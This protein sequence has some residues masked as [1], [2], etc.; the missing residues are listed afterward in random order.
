MGKIKTIN[1]LMKYMRDKHH[2]SIEGANDK[3]KLMN[4]GYYHGYKGYRYIKNPSNRLQ[5]NEFNEL[6][7]II[8]FDNNTKAILYPQVM[9]IETALKSYVLE[10]IVKM[11]KTDNFS[12]V[13]GEL[14]T[15]YKAFNSQSDVYKR[16]YK[17]RLDT[18]NIIQNEI[19]NA[20][21]HDSQI[22]SHYL[23]KD[24]SIPIWAIFEILT[25]G[26]FGNFVS[27]L[28]K[29]C[30]LA[31]SKELRLNSAFDSDGKMTESVIFAL[32]DLRNSIAHNNVI[33][34]TRFKNRNISQSLIKAIERD[35][36]IQGITFSSIT[37]YIILVIYM[38]KKFG[39]S[40]TEIKRLVWE[41]HKC[42]ENLRC[43]INLSIFSQ[44]ILT[45]DINKLKQLK[46]FIQKK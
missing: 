31:I 25:L 19:A 4:I 23:K 6:I 43:S 34:D 17:K 15:E 16:E 44:I 38:L 5:F 21:G 42:I 30:R 41:Y 12:K 22:I 8:N 33:F 1:G 24:E 7:A 39:K 26:Q 13:Y 20:Y 14:M 18:Y 32:K 2:I 40:K 11:G 29:N 28:N 45:N 36:L 37:D 10:V 46:I 9:F 27:T 3:K 35:T